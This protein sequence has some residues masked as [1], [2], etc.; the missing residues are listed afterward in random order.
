MSHFTEIALE[1]KDAACIK[2]ALEDM[3]FTVE[4]GDVA[5]KGY[6][7]NKQGDIVVRKSQLPSGCYGDMGFKLNKSTGNYDLVC[8]ELDLNAGKLKIDELKQNYGVRKVRSAARR[9]GFR[10]VRESRD[11]NKVRILL[12][13]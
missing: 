8:D 13:R 12:R 1:L 3:G 4:T 10:V 2:G 11:K 7:E 5:I 6:T 9:Q